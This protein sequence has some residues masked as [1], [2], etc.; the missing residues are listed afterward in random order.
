MLNAPSGKSVRM[1]ISPMPMTNTATR[2]S[3][4]ENPARRVMVISPLGRGQ[5]S[6]AGDGLAGVEVHVT[7]GGVRPVHR[8]RTDAAGLP[9]DDDE[10]LLA[11]VPEGVHVRRRG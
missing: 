5:G 9:L 2:T 1:A 6:R 4:S 3:I 11:A 10:H 8:R 7:A